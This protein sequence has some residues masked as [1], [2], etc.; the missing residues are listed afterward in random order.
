MTEMNDKLP[1]EILQMI[2]EYDKSSIMC[3][4]CKYW[5]NINNDHKIRI[6]KHQNLSDNFIQWLYK[7]Y[8][9]CQLTSALFFYNKP[10]ARTQCNSCPMINH[11]NNFWVFKK[12][13]SKR[14]RWR[15][16][17]IM[18]NVIKSGDIYFVQWLY[19]NDCVCKAK[20]FYQAPKE[21]QDYAVFELQMNVP[22]YWDKW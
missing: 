20:Y 21:V 9:S 7:N 15:S 1:V 6:S 18:K 10:L 8:G 2:Y 5:K 13:S 17:K 12:L 11:I 3:F 4:V 14:K 22:W 19:E 16:K